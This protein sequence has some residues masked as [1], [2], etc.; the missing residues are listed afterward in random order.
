MATDAG[1][2]VASPAR[3]V[4][5]GAARISFESRPRIKSFPRKMKENQTVL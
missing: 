1:D 5:R 2:P 4:P 3:T